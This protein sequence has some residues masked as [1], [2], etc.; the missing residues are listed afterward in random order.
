MASY[1]VG[2]EIGVNRAS[3]CVVDGQGAI[4]CRRAFGATSVSNAERFTDTLCDHLEDLLLKRGLQPGD[5]ERIGIAVAGGALMARGEDICAPE[6]F[7]GQAVP[8]HR[9]V[10]GRV[11]VD[12][13]VL[14]DAR[15][16]AIA[17]LWHTGKQ[18][19][20]LCLTL[21]RSVGVALVRGGVLQAAELAAACAAEAD[22]GGDV[23]PK[24]M[25][26]A[27]TGA[28]GSH[29]VAHAAR[30]RF[31]H[32]L[33]TEK[34]SARDVFAL[35]EQGDAEAR[36]L[37]GERVAALAEALVPVCARYGVREVVLAGALCPYQQL[38]IDPLNA[39]LAALAGG[40]AEAAIARQATCGGD[41]VMVGAALGMEALRD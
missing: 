21:S 37:I 2:V 4:L 34:L 20:Y 27:L 32:K 28:I 14:G 1:R 5:V 17:E 11:G 16:A 19:D 10:E 18:G 39:R 9:L 7:G 33:P 23:L 41:A 15:A 24:A 31:P 6:V 25:A 38:L 35:A 36:A 40:Q 12:P 3:M 22:A 26:E 13:A 30:L 29:A 8:L